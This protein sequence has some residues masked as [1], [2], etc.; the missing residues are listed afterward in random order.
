[1]SNVSSDLLPEAK[2]EI[3]EEVSISIAFDRQAISEKVI[4]NIVALSIRLSE[5]GVE[6]RQTFKVVVHVTLANVLGPLVFAVEWL[7]NFLVP[8]KVAVYKGNTARASGDW[9]P[10]GLRVVDCVPVA[11]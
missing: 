11:L 2:A 1:M 5:A 9:A 6:S 3:T 10:E 4:C 7:L 8:Y